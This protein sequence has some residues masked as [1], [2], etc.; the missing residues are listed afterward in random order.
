MTHLEENILG[1]DHGESKVGFA[2]KHGGTNT[3][4]GLEVFAREKGSQEAL[5]EKVQ[6]VINDNQIHRV[7][8]GLP[9]NMEGKPTKQTDIVA[10]FIHYLRKAVSIPVE[11]ADERLTS[12]SVADGAH[13]HAAA[14]ILQTYLERTENAQ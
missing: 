10:L 5:I 7:V 9:L 4:V 14:L 8:V 13:D 11:E 6:H 2:I 12:V 1:I 3:A